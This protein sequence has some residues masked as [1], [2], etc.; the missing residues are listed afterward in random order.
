MGFFP[1]VMEKKNLQG[2]MNDSIEVTDSVLDTILNFQGID[3]IAFRSR[4]AVE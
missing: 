2:L 3:P 1:P 4:G